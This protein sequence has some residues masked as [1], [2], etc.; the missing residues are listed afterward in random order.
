[1]TTIGDIALGLRRQSA[2]P[3]DELSISGVPRTVGDMLSGNRGQTI[4]DL[5]GIQRPEFQIPDAPQAPGKRDTWRDVLGSVLD[6]I[7]IAGGREGAY[8]GNVQRQQDQ[9]REDQKDYQA[10]QQQVNMANYKG[11][12]SLYEKAMAAAQPDWGYEQD[13]A[14]NVH[15]Y[16]KRTGKFDPN[17]VFVDPNPKMFMQG[18]KLVTVPNTYAAQGGG[19]P[20]RPVGKLTPIPEGGPTPRASGSFR[21]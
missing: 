2:A 8:W 1:M 12:L 7:A 18:D 19:T 13:N 20:D 10:L 3:T 15:R 14:G 5:I 4:G 6:T 21:Y 9:Y 17:P 16:D 11:D